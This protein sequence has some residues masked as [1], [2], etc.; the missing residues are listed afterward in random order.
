MNYVFVLQKM[1]FH[2]NGM[3]YEEI[4]MIT[5]LNELCIHFM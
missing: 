1:I 2:I 3:Q 5:Y 4:Q